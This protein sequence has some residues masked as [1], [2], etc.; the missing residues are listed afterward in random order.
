M[1]GFLEWIGFGNEDKTEKA[2]EAIEANKKTLQQ[3]F[4]TNEGL[5]SDYMDSMRGMYGSSPEAY[6]NALDA[7]MNNADFAY[8][9]NTKEFFSPAYEQRVKEAM[10]NIT[11]SQANAGNMFSSD[12]LNSLNAKSQAM[13]SEEWDK[14]FERMQR[15]RSNALQEYQLKDNK[16]SNIAS[17]L[18]NDQSSYANALGSYY[19]N[20]INNSNALTQG[21]ADL[22]T[23]IAQNNLNEKSSWQ[24]LLN[25]FG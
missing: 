24:A 16:L 1:A 6:K 15:D 22:N 18:S 3:G 7:Y 23:Q 9:K 12:Y 20:R 25:P 5:I 14:A 4:N 19:T 17:M 11:K 8:N 13:A 21:L 10:N 2:N